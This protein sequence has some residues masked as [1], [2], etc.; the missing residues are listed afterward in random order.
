MLDQ[1]T[2]GHFIGYAIDGYDS[3]RSAPVSTGKTRDEA[4]SQAI[5]RVLSLGIG[6]GEIGIR[7]NH[8]LTEEQFAKLGETLDAWFAEKGIN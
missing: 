7:E 1:Q 2:T 5:T 4:M 6:D 8:E 3:D